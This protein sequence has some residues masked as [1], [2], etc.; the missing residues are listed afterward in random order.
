MFQAYVSRDLDDI[1]AIADRWRLETARTDEF[2]WTDRHL[3]VRAPAAHA[4]TSCDDLSVWGSA[5]LDDC[6][7]PGQAATKTAAL[8]F[9]RRTIDTNGWYGISDLTGRLGVIV[10]NA[11]T[12]RL[13]AVRDAFGLAPL[14]YRV[15]GDRLH[16]ADSTDAFAERSTVCRDFLAGFLVAAQPPGDTTIWEGVRQVPQGTLF[17]WTPQGTTTRVYWSAFNFTQRRDGDLTE[18]AR[19]FGRLVRHAVSQSL[20]PEGRTWSDLS[21]GLD[22]STVACVAAYESERDP[23]RRLGGTMTF[24]GSIGDEDETRFVDAVLERY[25]VRHLRFHDDWPWR[26]DG[27]P[28]PHTPQPFR[29]YPFYARDRQCIR[30]LTAEGATMLL[31]GVGPDNYLPRTSLHVPDL[32]WTGQVCDG[33]REL[34]SSAL[35]NRERLWTAVASDVVMPVLPARL[36]RW[37]AARRVSRPEWLRADFFSDTRYE[38][39]AVERGINRARPGVICQTRIAE[40]F[41]DTSRALLGWRPF[42]PIAVHHPLLYRPLVEFCLELPHAHRTS[43]ASFKPILRAAMR[44]IVPDAVLGR[45]TKGFSRLA[46]YGWAITRERDR[47]TRLVDTSMLAELGC[48]EPRRL[49]AA[50]DRIACGQPAPL[51]NVCYALS[52]ETWLSV[53]YGRY[54]QLVTTT[55]RTDHEYAHQSRTTGLVPQPA[56]C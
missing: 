27:E 39:A 1:A 4:A 10:W 53:H 6:P 11:R 15:T 5:R 35:F 42:A 7:A 41:A 18:N 50:I 51:L 56:A 26:D 33:A 54:T 12:C 8:A 23:N 3:V 16:F 37:A 55:R 9:V 44:G 40:R 17:E 29:D 22:S 52:L 30:A 14:F 13:T 32:I 46:R 2:V 31:S 36:Q 20:D 47:L 49:R 28:P 21:G 19:E 38:T 43:W 48:I 25:P 45:R 34:W 24:A